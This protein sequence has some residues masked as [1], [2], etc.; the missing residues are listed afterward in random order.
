MLTPQIWQ[1]G[2]NLPVPSTKME[3]RQCWGRNLHAGGWGVI[4]ELSVDFYK[5]KYSEA[6]NQLYNI[7]EEPKLP[8]KY[9][10]SRETKHIYLKTFLR[11]QFAFAKMIGTGLASWAHDLLF[12]LPR[13]HLSLCLS[14]IIYHFNS[15][16]SMHVTFTYVY[17][18][19]KNRQMR[20]VWRIRSLQY[21]ECSATTQTSITQMV[22]FCLQG[23]GELDCFSE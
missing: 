1:K 18:H 17:C 7:R 11:I 4:Q 20:I 2:F 8:C 3:S 21:M 12:P 14:L 13:A 22:Y 5:G 16:Q 9:L 23:F 15:A 10:I 6:A 19:M